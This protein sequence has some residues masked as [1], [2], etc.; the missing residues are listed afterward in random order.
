M[1]K[2]N[3][4]VAKILWCING[5]HGTGYAITLGKTAY[6]SCAENLVTVQWRAHENAHK[7]QWARDGKVKFLRRY[8]WQFITKGYWN[9]DYEI[10]A[11][12]RASEV[13]NADTIRR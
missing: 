11:R 5:R 1:D 9:I 7:L 12:A 6:Y 13:K 4:W 2:Y 3:H 10:E 8:L